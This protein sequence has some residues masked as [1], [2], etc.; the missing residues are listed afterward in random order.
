MDACK[1]PIP[2]PLPGPGPVRAR[3]CRRW[4]RSGRRR[5]VSLFPPNP[6]PPQELG[7]ATFG[8]GERVQLFPCPLLPAKI[9]GAGH[10]QAPRHRQAVGVAARRSFHSSTSCSQRALAWS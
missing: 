8:S 10:L 5:S 4:L 7:C 2:R 1:H 9:G 3:W 6:A